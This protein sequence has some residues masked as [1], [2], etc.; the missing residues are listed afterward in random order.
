VTRSAC[1]QRSSLWRQTGSFMKTDILGGVRAASERR[2]PAQ[3]PPR[4]ATN[5]QHRCQTSCSSPH[6]PV[7]LK[8]PGL[9]PGCPG[10][11]DDESSGLV[12]RLHHHHG[13]RSIKTSRLNR[14]ATLPPASDATTMVGRP[15]TQTSMISLGC[16]WTRAEVQRT[17][18]QSVGPTASG[19]VAYGCVRTA[20]NYLYGGRRQPL[21]LQR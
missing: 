16:R 8:L 15:N 4:H 11:T 21:T 2:R 7:R 19:A 6:W 18:T 14:P 5:S 20:S 13:R 9:P 12:S 1:R 10:E 17:R 3:G